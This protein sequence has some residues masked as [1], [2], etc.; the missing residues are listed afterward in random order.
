MVGHPGNDDISNNEYHSSVSGKKAI[1]KY[2]CEQNFSSN[3]AFSISQ[4]GWGAVSHA[5]NNRD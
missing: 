2:P 1:F 4:V 3:M 5:V